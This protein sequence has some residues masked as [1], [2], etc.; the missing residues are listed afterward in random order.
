[1]R[2]SDRLRGRPPTAV[3]DPQFARLVRRVE[4]LEERFNDLLA[5][6]AE[7]WSPL[8]NDARAKA[9]P[10]AEAAAGKRR[11]RKPEEGGGGPAG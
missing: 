6:I 7:P 2:R 1:L 3:D 5:A 11:R 9:S 10:L 4:A 8:S